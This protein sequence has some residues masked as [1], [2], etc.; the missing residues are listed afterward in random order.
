MSRHLTREELV[1]FQNKYCEYQTALTRVARVLA[2]IDKPTFAR[3]YQAASQEYHSDPQKYPSLMP[4]DPTERHT[5]YVAIDHVL[6]DKGGNNTHECVLVV[7]P[8]VCW[9]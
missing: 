1:F 7:L 8:H 3:Q 6:A 9:S 4:M 2:T 5:F